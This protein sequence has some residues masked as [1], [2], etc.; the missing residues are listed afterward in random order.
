MRL[1]ALAALLPLALPAAAQ[2][3]AS[4]P[5]HAPTSVLLLQ[6]RDE[7]GRPLPDAQVVVAGVDRRGR[8]D[9]GGEAFVDEVPAGNRI[10][11]ATRPGYAMVRVAADFMGGDTVRR[12]VRMTPQA[13]E[14]EGV[15]ATSWGR[16]MRLRRNGFY[17]RQRAGLGASMTSDRIEMLR[18]MH[19]NELFRY[20]RGFK[21]QLTRDGP[22]VLGTRGGGL[23]QYCV[24]VVY[25]DGLALPSGSIKDQNQ[26]LESVRPD[27]ILAIEAFQGPASI[28][29][30]YNPLGSACGVILIWTRAGG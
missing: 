17:D 3:P 25:V 5:V 24:P 20:M 7:K 12:E 22:V 19:T 9:A 10:V 18:P 1:L 8:S 28:P 16:S 23:A 2:I 30:E 11:E 4:P 21:I 26:A 14:L 15:T 13:V 27:D 29:A 6:V